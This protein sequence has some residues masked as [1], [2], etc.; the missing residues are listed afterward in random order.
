MKLK[1][2]FSVLMCAAAFLVFGE[3]RAQA[4]DCSFQVEYISKASVS[5]D[6]AEINESSNFAIESLSEL[7]TLLESHG[8]YFHSNSPQ[9][10][11][12]YVS[13]GD[14][15]SRHE[16]EL[17]ISTN[18]NGHALTAQSSGKGINFKRSKDKALRR[19]LKDL[20]QRLQEC[21]RV[22]EDTGL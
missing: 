11:Q 2:Y 5:G 17:K 3:A 12:L 13:S 16:I 14:E 15:Q 10:V 22:N 6:D 19:V 18:L 8:Y 9:I 20:E 4:Q 1:N 7:T 21:S